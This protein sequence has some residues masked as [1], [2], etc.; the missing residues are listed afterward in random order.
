LV[1]SSSMPYDAH[2]LERAD[3]ELIREP[4]GLSDFCAEP[5]C[6]KK[7]HASLSTP[8]AHASPCFRLPD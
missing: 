8:A 2:C 7:I 6:S 5:L 4:S 1:S 3:V